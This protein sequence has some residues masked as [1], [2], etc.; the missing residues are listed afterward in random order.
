[1]SSEFEF[2]R[3]LLL[4]LGLMALVN[5]SRRA[6][7]CNRG[8]VPADRSRSDSDPRAL[9]ARLATADR[10]EARVE[11]LENRVD[12]AERLIARREAPL[13]DRGSSS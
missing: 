3:Y 5:W 1:M 12:F 7:R 10:L 8:P 6:R 9:E 4:F 2:L 11:E 13:L